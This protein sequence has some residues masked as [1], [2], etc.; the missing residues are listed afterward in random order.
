MSFRFRSLGR[1]AMRIAVAF[2]AFLL[3]TLWA[4]FGGSHLIDLADRIFPALVGYPSTDPHGRGTMDAAD[5]GIGLFLF[6]LLGLVGGW[7]GWLAT[8]R[9]N[10]SLDLFISAPI[11]LLF[12]AVAGANYLHFD[13]L[14]TRDAQAVLNILLVA[15]GASVVFILQK[16]T[17]RIRSMFLRVLAACLLSLTIYAFVVIPLWYSIDFVTWKLHAGKIESAESLA[18]TLGAVG[19]LLAA[20]G[21]TWKGGALSFGSVADA[22][23]KEE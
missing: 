9:R 3:V 15:S 13:Q 2:V 12:A 18:K 8:D 6:L 19:S 22:T 20:V 11:F 17:E 1:I 5:A 21:L 14:F 23:L 10:W 16:S 7:L 4:V